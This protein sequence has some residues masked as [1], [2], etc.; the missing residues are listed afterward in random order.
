VLASVNLVLT[1]PLL[2]WRELLAATLAHVAMNLPRLMIVQ[3]STVILVLR[4]GSLLTK[5]LAKDALLAM[6]PRLDRALARHVPLVLNLIPITPRCL[7]VPPVRL[8]PILLVMAP[9]KLVLPEQ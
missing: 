9:V 6:F 1:G 4:A 8:A 3:I 2:T 7:T 5:D